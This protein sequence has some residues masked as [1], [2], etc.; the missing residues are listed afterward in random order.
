[1]FNVCA[2]LCIVFPLV[3]YSPKFFEYRYGSW[4]KR[5][6]RPV[7]CRNFF[8]EQQELAVLERTINY[9]KK[10][11]FSLSLKIVGCLNW[12][13]IPEV[14]I[15]YFY[16]YRSLTPICQIQRRLARLFGRLNLTKSCLLRLMCANW[17]CSTVHSFYLENEDEDGDGDAV[18]RH[19]AVQV[20][21][22]T[23]L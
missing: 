12:T 11:R 9:S 19:V 1:M 15:G 5:V 14:K 20:D 23:P 10:V 16:R 17:R 22:V 21:D 3:F 7:D 4:V 2:I 18:L 6:T 13:N 8:Y